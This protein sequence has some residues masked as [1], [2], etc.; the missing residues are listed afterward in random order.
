MS[1]VP[2]MYSFR[3][4]VF[5]VCAPI[6]LITIVATPKAISRPPATNPPIRKARFRC[7]AGILQTLAS[8]ARTVRA[9]D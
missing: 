2:V 8:G 4:F 1:G 5:T 7:T 3:R 6:A 9:I